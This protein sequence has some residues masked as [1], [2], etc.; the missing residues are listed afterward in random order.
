M[1]LQTDTEGFSAMALGNSQEKPGDEQLLVR[2]YPVPKENKSKSEEAGRPIFEERE[3]ISIMVPGNKDSIIER[4]VSDLDRARF[5]RHY[6][7]FKDNRAQE[8]E[9]TMLASWPGITRAQVEELRFLNIVTVEQLAGMSDTH[10]QKF[11]GLSGLKTRAK[12]F[13]EAAASNSNN[14]KTAAALEEKD[15]KIAGL[16]GQIAE[17]TRAFAEL[18]ESNAVPDSSGDNKRRSSRSRAKP[19]E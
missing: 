8:V 9:G 17:L 14:E 16:E 12:L 3:Y 13:M 7:A 6:A 5:P 19:V 15:Q 4:P 10:T 2:F 18:K 1:A 11:M